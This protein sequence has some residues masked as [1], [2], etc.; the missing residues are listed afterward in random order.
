MSLFLIIDHH[1]PILLILYYPT[2]TSLYHTH[3]R[4][5]FHS[6]IFSTQSFFNNHFFPF[7]RLIP[8][9]IHVRISIYCH[10]PY[11]QP[12]FLP[13]LI[14]YLLYLFFTHSLHQFYPF[15][16]T[17]LHLYPFYLLILLISITRSLHLFHLH[18]F[19]LS[20]SLPIFSIRLLY[21][22]SP[23]IP[24]T[25]SLYPFTLLIPS[26]H[27]SISSFPPSSL[28]FYQLSPPSTRMIY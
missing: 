16:F 6:L 7:S 12:T 27:F 1:I 19:P 18:P 3:S 25:R 21:T 22:P 8:L 2:L 10:H 28:S 24:F 9:P 11:S 4:H 13:I 5:P 23:F 14:T 20:I 17:T 15:I 26:T